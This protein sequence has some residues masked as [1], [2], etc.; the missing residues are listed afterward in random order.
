[1]KAAGN[2]A[3]MV[4]RAVCWCMAALLLIT[5]ASAFV[6]GTAPNTPETAEGYQWE[7]SSTTQERSASDKHTDAA[8]VE[9]CCMLCC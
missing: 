5:A 4:L 7:G 3:R 9:C 6:C 2:L 1:M 8:V